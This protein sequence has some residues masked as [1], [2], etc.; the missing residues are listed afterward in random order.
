[1]PRFRD[2]RLTELGFEQR[3]LQN[4]V[5]PRTIDRFSEFYDAVARTDM[6][7]EDET[8]KNKRTLKTVK[9][10]DAVSQQIFDFESKLGL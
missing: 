8:I 2:N 5:I 1:M 6:K 3:D 9:L 10:R 7:P 4:V